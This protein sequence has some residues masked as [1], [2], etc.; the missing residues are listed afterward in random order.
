M[1]KLLLAFAVLCVGSTSMAA[2][3]NICGTTVERVVLMNIKSTVN[4]DIESISAKALERGE[5]VDICAIGSMPVA[6]TKS[7]TRTGQIF[8]TAFIF[9]Q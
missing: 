9:Q 4:P 2:T 7:P 6:I 1:K 5:S 8:K 3:I